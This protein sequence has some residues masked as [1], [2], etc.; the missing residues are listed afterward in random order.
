MYRFVR[1]GHSAR[2]YLSICL[3]GGLSGSGRESGVP[4]LKPSSPL[5]NLYIEHRAVQS[6]RKRDVKNE[7]I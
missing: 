1:Q 3:N 6:L 7:Q 4:A 5:P 2:M